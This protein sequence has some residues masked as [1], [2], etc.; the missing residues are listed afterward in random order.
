[1]LTDGTQLLNSLNHVEYSHLLHY[2]VAYIG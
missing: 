1:M 2:A